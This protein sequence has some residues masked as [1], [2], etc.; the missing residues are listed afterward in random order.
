MKRCIDA[1]LNLENMYP[2][3]AINP[4]DTNVFVAEVCTSPDIGHGGICLL[5][6]CD[7]AIKS[8]RVLYE[9]YLSKPLKSQPK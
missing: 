1:P 5:Y 3:L 4:C 2:S 9:S 6:A 8:R 7:N